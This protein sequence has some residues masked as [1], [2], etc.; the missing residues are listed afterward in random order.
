MIS[1][2]M[3][4]S[5]SSIDAFFQ[6][7]TLFLRERA[8]GMYRTSSYFI[9][10]V[11]TDILPM[12]VF[13]A[14]LMGGPAYWMIGLRYDFYHFL[15][16][17]IVLVLVSICGGTMCLLISAGSP[18]LGMG[19]LVSIL[20]MLFYMLFG[21]F[22][23]I[24]NSI[25]SALRWMQYF[26]FLNFAFEILVT[27]EFQGTDI[28]INPDSYGNFGPDTPTTVVLGADKIFKRFDIDPSRIT[29][30]YIGLGISVL[31]YLLFAYLLL[32]FHVKEHR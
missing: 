9:A 29:L 10:K 24:K 25:P 16:F 28:V 26:S 23:I 1:I 32:R 13:P 7:R 21:G 6:E 17:M 4:A 11:F 2:L 30:D 31:V 3:F 20:I 22:L 27:N 18:N 14:I 19:N 8:N 12:R 15:V 5:M